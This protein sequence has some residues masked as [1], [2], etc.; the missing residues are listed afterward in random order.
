MTKISILFAASTIGR[1]LPNMVA[2]KFGV[3]NLTVFCTAACGILV[4]CLEACKDVAAVFIFSGVFG[5][6]S[7]AG[8]L[9]SW[10]CPE[11]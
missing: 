10:Y 1:I 5:F 2:Q 8:E 11:I 9:P 7:G 4:F 3:F 6:F